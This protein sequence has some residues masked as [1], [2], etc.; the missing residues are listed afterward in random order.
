MTTVGFRRASVRLP[1]ARPTHRMGSAHNC[2]I[3][4]V[5]D[6]I[7]VRAVRQGW[8]SIWRINRVCRFAIRRRQDQNRAAQVSEDG[9]SVAARDESCR[10]PATVGAHNKQI[11]PV[12]AGRNVVR[13]RTNQDVGLFVQVQQQRGQATN[14]VAVENAFPRVANFLRGRTGRLPVCRDR[15]FGRSCEFRLPQR[16]C[17]S[18]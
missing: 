8:L 7:L 15:H 11:I 9:F 17:A 2:T 16:L 10:P 5:S 13:A 18:R 3:L 1:S 4:Q 6:C 14:I 12:D